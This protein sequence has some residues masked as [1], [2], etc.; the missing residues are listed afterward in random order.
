MSDS[1][2]RR[3]DI[4]THILPESMPDWNTKFP[5]KEWIRL[6]KVDPAH[7]KDV[8]KEIESPDARM[9]KG[10]TFFRCVKVGAGRL[11]RG[12]RERQRGEGERGTKTEGAN[13]PPQP[14]PTTTTER[15]PTATTAPPASRRWT[16]RA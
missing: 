3:I 12:V 9:Y 5:Y 6:E 4:H 15:R 16:S 1:P 14:P 10:D 7:P 8:D 13:P 11:S 2:P